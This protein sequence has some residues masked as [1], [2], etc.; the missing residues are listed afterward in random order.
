M[1]KII[2]IPS[3]NL[4]NS[5]YSIYISIYHTLKNNWY[6]CYFLQ[7]NKLFKEYLN[8]TW[9]KNDD[10]LEINEKINYIKKYKNSEK[11]E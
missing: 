4:W 5:W 1:N 3:K 6:S 8:K 7:P 2:W 10:I 11:K 9:V